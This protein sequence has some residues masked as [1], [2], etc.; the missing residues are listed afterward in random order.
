MHGVSW[1]SSGAIISRGCALVASIVVA[2]E[3]GLRSFGQFGVIQSTVAM[4]QTF[5]GF[6]IGEMAT[7]YIAELRLRDPDRASR[8]AGLSAITAMVVGVAVLVLVLA[9]AP[10]IARGMLD[11]PE[12]GRIIRISTPI[13]LFG[14]LIGA[15][16][17][18]LSGLEAFR[19]SAL[20]S[21]AT[22]CVSLPLL[23]AGARFGG[24]RGAVWGLVGTSIATWIVSHLVLRREFRRAGL[25]ITFAGC[26]REY[27][28]LVR[29]SIPAL[30][31]GLM[32]TPVYWFCVT[33][34]VRE[35]NG[36]AEMGLFNAANQWFQALLFLPNVIA[37]VV[38]PLLSHRLGNGARTQALRMLR[39]SMGVN[40]SFAGLVALILIVLSPIIMGSYGEGFRSGWPTLVIV[41]L[42]SALVAAQAPVGQFIAA[43]GKMWIGFAMNA[44]WAITFIG[45]AI[46]LVRYG[47]EG[48]AGARLLAYVLHCVWTFWYALLLQ[49]KLVVVDATPLDARAMAL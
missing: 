19:T 40:A 49:R 44:G 37:Q 3:L 46:G 15:Q 35:P 20:V 28:A 26:W 38:F 1:I 8:V 21:V 24:V 33:L 14:A 41:V 13:L 36:Y 16:A 34:L 43:S 45:L 47:A 12:L 31:G 9:T 25:T 6:G 42:T 7:K 32:V 48:L 22:G 39:I 30:L 11:A 4:F 18:A 23:I 27:P 29:F 5:A 2:R 17:G 10:I